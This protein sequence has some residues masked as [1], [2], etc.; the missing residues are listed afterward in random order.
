M[1]GVDNIEKFDHCLKSISEKLHAVPLVVQFPIGAGKE[2]KGVV[3]IVEQKA[4]YFQMGDRDENYQVKE[5]PSELL[6]LAKKYQ[7]ELIEKIID[8]DEN[9]ALKYYESNGELQLQVREIK[10]L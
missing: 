3:D 4:Y 2:L 6:N 7:Q 5:I 10:K 9:L 1:D 8:Y